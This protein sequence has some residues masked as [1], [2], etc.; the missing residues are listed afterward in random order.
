V[1]I[2]LFPALIV[3]GFIPLLSL[4]ACGGKLAQTGCT[5]VT[6]L[7][8]DGIMRLRYGNGKVAVKKLNGSSVPKEIKTVSKNLLKPARFV[9]TS[10]GSTLTFP[11]GDTVNYK[12]VKC[13]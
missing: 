13:E 8:C 3:I 10:K 5:V 7:S 1:K 12:E 6:G 9:E 4:G 2:R 11:N